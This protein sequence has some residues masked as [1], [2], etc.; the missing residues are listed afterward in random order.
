MDFARLGGQFPQAVFEFVFAGP[1]LHDA[2]MADEAHFVIV[3]G[4]HEYVAAGLSAA[5]ER[6]GLKRR[7]AY[8]QHLAVGFID[9]HAFAKREDVAPVALYNFFGGH[10]QQ[11]DQGRIHG[12]DP[13]VGAHPG[14]A[15]VN[16]IDGDGFRVQFI[17]ERLL[18][19][20]DAAQCDSEAG[21]QTKKV[22]P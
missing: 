1:I 5:A 9:A 3:H 6:G 11:V 16:V 13:A 4:D 20:A 21:R 18:A 8:Q 10:V 17:A 7:P 22:E 19:K 14:D 2:V 15:A 12:S